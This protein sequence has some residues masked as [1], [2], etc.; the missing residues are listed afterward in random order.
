MRSGYQDAAEFDQRF[1]IGHDLNAP[2][3]GASQSGT[4]EDAVGEGLAVDPVLAHLF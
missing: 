2:A 3:E 4:A 1:L